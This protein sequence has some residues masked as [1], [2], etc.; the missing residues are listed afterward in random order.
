MNQSQ[1]SVRKRPL[2][3]SLMDHSPHSD[4]QFM[5]FAVDDYFKT[6]YHLRRYLDFAHRS[7]EAARLRLDLVGYSGYILSFP[8]K[9]FY[10]FNFLK[11]IYK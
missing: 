1:T 4:L 3:E 9:Y 2:G 10:I 7:C 8:Q 5:D 6:D 11:K